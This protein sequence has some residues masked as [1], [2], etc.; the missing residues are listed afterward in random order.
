MISTHVIHPVCCLNLCSTDLL[1]LSFPDYDEKPIMPVKGKASF[2][3][4]FH[5]GHIATSV[6]GYCW[7]IYNT[8]SLPPTT[9]GPQP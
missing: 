6:L 7:V 3:M 1:L 4:A 9:S 5:P 2:G 8:S